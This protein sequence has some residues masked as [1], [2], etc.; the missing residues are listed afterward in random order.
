MLPITIKCFHVCGPTPDLFDLCSE[1]MVKDLSDVRVLKQVKAVP[2]QA[3]A[4]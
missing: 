2:V 1:M 4:L 3:A